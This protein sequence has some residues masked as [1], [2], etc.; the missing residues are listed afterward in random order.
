MKSLSCISKRPEKLFGIITKPAINTR[1]IQ[2]LNPDSPPVKSIIWMI[3]SATSNFQKQRNL[4]LQDCGQQHTKQNNKKT[5]GVTIS[6]HLYTESRFFIQIYAVKMGKCQK[7]FCTKS[8]LSDSWPRFFLWVSDCWPLWTP[9]VPG[10][11]KGYPP[12]PS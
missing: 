3:K 12:S 6:R 11:D 9:G 4:S 2:T 10:A 1:K 8:S 5:L 7:I